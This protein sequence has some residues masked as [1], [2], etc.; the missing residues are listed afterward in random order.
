[1]QLIEPFG[2]GIDSHII[3]LIGQV[4][5]FTCQ[6]H[7][8]VTS[9]IQFTH[10]VYFIGPYSIG[11]ERYRYSRS[12]SRL[13]SSILDATIYVSLFG[14]LYLYVSSM[15][16]IFIFHFKGAKRLIY[17]VLDQVLFTIVNLCSK[18]AIWCQNSNNDS[19]DSYFVRSCV[20]D[21]AISYFINLSQDHFHNKPL[22]Q[23][24]ILHY[25]K[26]SRKQLPLYATLDQ[27][28]DLCV[29]L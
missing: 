27:N 20:S 6:R 5:A 21:A 17:L 13:S 1:M 18:G 12:L 11:T 19:L 29:N 7:V 16:H 8:N 10:Q 3:L 28:S 9:G 23:G 14:Q 22:S 15:S 25:F 4:L 2:L 24:L 26:I